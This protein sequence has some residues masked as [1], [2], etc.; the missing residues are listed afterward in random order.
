[1]IFLPA[2]RGWLLAIGD[3]FVLASKQ[4][5]L[6]HGPIFQALCRRDAVIFQVCIVAPFLDGD[7][8]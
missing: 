7:A 4:S 5:E 1:M 8:C 6:Y 2:S 3:N